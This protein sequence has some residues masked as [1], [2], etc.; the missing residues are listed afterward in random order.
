MVL[1]KLGRGDYLT[2]SHLALELCQLNIVMQML[3]RDDRKRRAVH[4]FGDKE[5]V[6]IIHSLFNEKAPKDLLKG[7]I[8][9]KILYALYQAAEQMDS[10][11]AG[12]CLGYA[13][14]TNTLRNIGLEYFN[15]R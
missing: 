11:T 5:D 7:N 13:S 8:E 12:L 3:V 6:P 1:A 2:A 4:R 14:K 9:N 15:T 10:M